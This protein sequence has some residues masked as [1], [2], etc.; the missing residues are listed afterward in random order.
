MEL[1]ITNCINDTDYAHELRI[2]NIQPRQILYIMQQIIGQTKKVYTNLTPNKI[3]NNII[4]N[5]YNSYIDI[6]NDPFYKDYKPT[7]INLTINWY[8]SSTDGINRQQS[9]I[10]GLEQLLQHTSTVK[11]FDIIVNEFT[12]D[13]NS[14]IQISP[15]N[16]NLRNVPISLFSKVYR[17]FIKVGTYIY[18]DTIRG[19][20]ITVLYDKTNHIIYFDKKTEYIDDFDE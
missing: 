13:S 12:T 7:S 14:N 17:D 6:Y 9:T 4:A 11:P 15:I 18:R 20:Y 2:Q 10:T 19:N 16:Y 5:A 1:K 3:V 8:I